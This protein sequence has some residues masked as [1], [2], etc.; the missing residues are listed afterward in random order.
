[1]QTK[2]SEVFHCWQFHSGGGGVDPWSAVSF[3]LQSLS[4]RQQNFE[5]KFC[6]TEIVSFQFMTALNVKG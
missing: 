5:K 1:M 4:D 2:K 3:S 6:P